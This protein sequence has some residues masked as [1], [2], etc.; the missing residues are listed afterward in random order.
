[1]NNVEITSPVDHDTWNEIIRADSDA[2]V[3]QSPNWL[4][5]ACLS[6]GFTN[7]SRLYVFSSGQRIV[8]PLV[9]KSVLPGIII[10]ASMPNAWG[11][12][13]LLKTQPV[14]T[15]ELAVIFEDLVG[16][17]Y[18]QI[19][20]RANPLHTQLWESAAPPHIIRIPR[21]SHIINLEGG[22]TK[23]WETRFKKDARKNVNKAENRGVTIESDTTERLVP[24]FYHL[25]W[26]AIERWSR[27]Q[28]EPLALARIR[29]RRRDPI[30][31]FETIMRLGQGTCKIWLARVNGEPAAA[32][33]VLQNRNAQGTRDPMN[34]S[35]AAWAKANYLLEK[36]AIEDACAAG[37]LNYHLGESG[38]SPSLAF[39]KMRFGAE[40]YPYFE[41][42][43]EHMPITAMDKRLKSTV[44]RIIGFRDVAETTPPQDEPGSKVADSTTDI[45]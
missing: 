8:L 44:K 18:A 34:E 33:L 31:K 20:I 24:I 23:V 25:F 12:G 3:T 13:G 32:M 1:M 45:S 35:L 21:R 2:L 5:A 43:I 28:H 11:V 41:Y 42:R 38:D 7:A 22:F 39:H 30:E 19:S 27:I 29:A 9:K 40:D 17:H 10:A 36:Y 16:L 4:E 26:T 37:C 6:G 15:D 14:T